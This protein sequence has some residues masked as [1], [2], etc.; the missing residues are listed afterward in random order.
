MLALLGAGSIAL[1]A[2][3]DSTTSSGGTGGTGGMATSSS[4][5]GTGGM[6]TSSS[7]SGTGGMATSSSSSG[8][9]G[10]ATSSSSSGTGGMATSSSSSSGTGGMATSSSS[11]GTG[12]TGG[13]APACTNVFQGSFTIQNTIDIATISPYCEITG[14]LTIK[15]AGVTS[16][17]LP[18]LQKVDGMIEAPTIPDLVSISLPALISASRIR[19]QGQFGALSTVQMPAL[20]A[21]AMSVEVTGGPVSVVDMT[22][23]Q[24]GD[25]TIVGNNATNVNVSLPHM[26]SGSVIIQ[27][28]GSVS[29]PS[30]AHPSLVN[31]TGSSIDMSSLATADIIDA[32][33]PT[34]GFSFPML[35]SVSQT[36][37]FWTAGPVSA[38]SLV[39]VGQSLLLQG[40]S[41]VSLPSLTT[42]GP[43]PS[44]SSYALALEG[45]T[46]T[47]LDLPSLS[48]LNGHLWL[49]KPDCT[50]PNT[51]LT[52][53]HFPALTVLGSSTL[54]ADG[55]SCFLDS[56]CCSG[57]C[58]GTTCGGGVNLYIDVF[59]NP[60]LP[61]CR[62][63]ALAAQ[64]PCG[65]QANVAQACGGLATGP[66]P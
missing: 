34:A 47:K 22:A 36:A 19:L 27:T 54:K 50:L 63:D 66:C 52:Q 2:A 10:M 45:S 13:M 26:I 41:G 61:K 57:T 32:H 17:S 53:L 4:S 14:D 55:A 24:S 46:L 48:S 39:S 58:A 51:G 40:P 62:V 56:Q 60:L 65:S 6:A 42:I 16:I 25:V 8:T 15:A 20:T 44:A 1:P 21:V 33:T 11:S 18:L 64:F 49:G 23:F 43:P 3:C 30:L 28:S 37:W 5:S 59:A 29:V 35:T 12:G 38:P 7:S 9:G 31:V